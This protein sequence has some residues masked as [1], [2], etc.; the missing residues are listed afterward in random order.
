DGLLERKAGEVA[1][2]SPRVIAPNSLASEALGLMNDPDRPVLCIFVADPEQDGPP[3]GIL[4]VHDCLR[5][6]LDRT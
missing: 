5:A 2:R 4:H 1:T 6:G 3:V